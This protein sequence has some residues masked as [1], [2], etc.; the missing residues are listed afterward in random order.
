MHEKRFRTITENKLTKQTPSTK[1]SFLHGK[2]NSSEQKFVAKQ[3]VNDI[4]LPSSLAIDNISENFIHL[5]FR[6]DDISTDISQNNDNFSTGKPG[7]A[8]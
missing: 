7:Q 1:N 3:A 4:S 8:H 6:G 2:Y 5:R